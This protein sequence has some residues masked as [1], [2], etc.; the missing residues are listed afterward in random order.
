MILCSGPPGSCLMIRPSKVS[1]TFYLG[2]L[3]MN[4][5]ETLFSLGRGGCK[6]GSLKFKFHLADSKQVIC[7]FMS[8][9]LHLPIKGDKRPPKNVKVKQD[10][11]CEMLAPG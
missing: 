2:Y 4:H 8:A 3:F 11:T 9:R 1:R 6:V 10:D 5:Q 7:F